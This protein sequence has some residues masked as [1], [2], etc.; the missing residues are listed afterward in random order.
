MMG[1]EKLSVPSEENSG[2]YPKVPALRRLVAI[3]PKQGFAEHT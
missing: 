1:T 2:S 3:T